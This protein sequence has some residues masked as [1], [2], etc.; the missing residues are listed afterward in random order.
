MNFV[1][2]DFETAT[3]ERDSPC[4]LG[5]TFVEDSE[6]IKTK[7][8]LINPMYEEF[9]FFNTLIHGLSKLH[10]KN[11]PSFDVVWNEVYPLIEGKHV[12]AHNAGFDMSVLRNTLTSYKMSYPNLDYSCSYTFSKGAWPGLT[13]YGLQSLC[14]HHNIPLKHHRAGNDSLATAQLSLKAF[15]EIGVKQFEDFPT[16]LKTTIGRLYSD[17]YKPSG[18]VR[19]KPPAIE[20]K[21]DVSKHNINSIF[22][23]S[24]VLFTGVL[25][26]MPRNQAMQTIAD[27]GG[28]LSKSMS[29]K[30][31][32]L[33]VG[34]QDFRFVGDDGMSNKQEKAIKLI[35]KGSPLEILSEQDFLQNI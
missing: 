30:T 10:V 32:Y 23:G 13:S 14:Q 35:E 15:D 9:D 34:Q 8:W 16:K 5:V 26:S 18:K 27:I 29:N 33:I 11:S 31:D 1:T 19:I 21:G 22:Y 4:E 24:S 28:I 6:I 25:S 12:I 17:G 2:L 20:I 3:S 7:S